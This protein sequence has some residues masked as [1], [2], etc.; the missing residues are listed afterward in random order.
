MSDRL[1]FDFWGEG[2]AANN[3]F[4]MNGWRADIATLKWRLPHHLI[5]QSSRE[6][7]IR[8]WISD[9]R[10]LTTAAVWCSQTFHAPYRNCC[11]RSRSLPTLRRFI[12]SSPIL[13]SPRLVRASKA[14]NGM[15]QVQLV[16][17]YNN[18]ERT[19]TPSKKFS[20]SQTASS[21]SPTCMLARLLL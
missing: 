12:T 19:Y 21:C 1:I 16:G 6:G 4:E 13:F 10:N 9:F 2:N 17:N 5:K 7:E 3:S 18:W 11:T 8:S 14:C 15:L 20:H